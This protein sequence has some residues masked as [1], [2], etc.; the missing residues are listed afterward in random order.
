MP[1]TT[2]PT[3]GAA[4]DIPTKQWLHTL[5]LAISCCVMVGITAWPHF[6][7]GTVKELNHSAASLLMMGMSAGFVYG[8]GFQPRHFI[9]RYLFSAPVS[10]GLMGAGFLWTCLG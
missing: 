10:L 1:N 9:W 7:G 4:T 6:L 3:Q 8:I 2:S 5:V